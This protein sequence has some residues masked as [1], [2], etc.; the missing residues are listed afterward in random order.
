MF[1]FLGAVEYLFEKKKT[2][3]G[4]PI[5]CGLLGFLLAWVLPPVYRTEIRLR[6]D[7]A[8]ESSI[9]SLAGVSKSVLGGLESYVGKTSGIEPEDFY[10]EVLTGRDVSLKTI[11]KFKLDTLFKKDSRDLLLKRFSEE[12][13]VSLENTGIISCAFESKNKKLAQ[14]LLR[15]TVQT[16]NDKYI[17]L[18][19]NRLSQNLLYL[20]QLQANIQDSINETHQELNRF[21]KENEVIDLKS[22]LQITIAALAGY[23]EQIRNLKRSEAN[24][25][26]EALSVDELRRKRLLLEKEYAEIRFGKPGKSIYVNTNWAASKLV[27]QTQLEAR[28]ERQLKIHELIAS[29]IASTEAKA[30]K[31][32]P[33]IQIL[34][35]AYMPD[36]KTRP[37]RAV[38]ALGFFTISF[39]LI[40][41]SLL[42]HGI[43]SDK[44]EASPEVRDGIKRLIQSLRK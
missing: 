41:I 10:I 37:K 15:F 26:G 36:W 32:M 42:V 6:V 39:V 34:Q 40:S 17:D 11:D 4:V 5:L 43:V 23:E 30:M 25:G 2:V 18:Q 38:W 14:D 33:V 7:E 12:F 9:P 28:M 1:S 44:L 3:L 22:Q 31:S 19:R 20:R 16:A 13:D 24:L 35:D 29:E 21:L 8:T 27:E